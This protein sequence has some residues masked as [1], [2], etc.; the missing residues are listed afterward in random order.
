MRTILII[1]VLLP[2]YLKGQEY[3]NNNESC[4]CSEKTLAK[5]SPD[6]NIYVEDMAI[7]PGDIEGFIFF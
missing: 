4:N 2:L 5:P 6:G 1:F 7:Y 3:S